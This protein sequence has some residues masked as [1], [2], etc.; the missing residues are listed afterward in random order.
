MSRSGFS[1]TM[2][3]EDK[4]TGLVLVNLELVEK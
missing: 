3:I 2:M 4:L 1:K